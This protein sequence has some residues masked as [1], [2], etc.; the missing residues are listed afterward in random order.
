METVSTTRRS[1]PGT[2]PNDPDTDGDGLSDGE[3]LNTHGTDPNETD[4]D[5]D[6]LSDAD[7]LVF[8]GEPPSVVHG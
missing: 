4:T 7:E 2:D 5:K 6:G 1:L 8:S 3:E